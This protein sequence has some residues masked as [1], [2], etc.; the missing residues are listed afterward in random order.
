MSIGYR[1]A[2]FK[3]VPQLGI[4]FNAGAGVY[5]LRYDK[6][7]NEANGPVAQSGVREVRLLPD[8]FGVSL[9]YKFGNGGGH[10]KRG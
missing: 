4:E 3:D 9:Y 7:Y 8:T 2:P 1:L 5:S 10:V 6:F